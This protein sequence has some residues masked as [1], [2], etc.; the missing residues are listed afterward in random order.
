MITKG[1]GSANLIVTKGF[2]YAG[3]LYREIHTFVVRINRF[4]KERL[5]R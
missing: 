5:E 2:G 4:I 1:Y 3:E